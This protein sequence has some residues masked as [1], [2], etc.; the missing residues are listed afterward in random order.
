MTVLG[1]DLWELSLA[2][3]AADRDMSVEKVRAALETGPKSAETML[4]TGLMDKLGWPEDALQS[5]DDKVANDV[6]LISIMSYD[7]PPIK[8][9]SPIIALVGG[10][11]GIVTGSGGSSSPFDS[12]TSFGSDRIAGAIISAANDER[13]KAIVF[14]VDSG[15]GSPIASLLSFQWVLLQPPGD[16]M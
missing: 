15:G 10:E 16:I 8:P 7:A 13:V 14:R 9:G 1:E 4:E 3:I 11:G 5:A 6:T 12:G 2:D